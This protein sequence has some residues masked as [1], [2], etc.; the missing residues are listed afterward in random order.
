MRVYNLFVSQS[1]LFSS[2]NTLNYSIF[3]IK[4]NKKNTQLSYR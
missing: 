2:Y 3:I 1:N 4:K